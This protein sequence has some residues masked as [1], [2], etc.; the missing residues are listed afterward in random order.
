M[1]AA[2]LTPDEIKARSDW[3]IFSRA[4]FDGGIC[5]RIR[6]L[7]IGNLLSPRILNILNQ[8][9]REQRPS[10]Y[11]GSPYMEQ[12]PSTV[13][14]KKHGNKAKNNV[15]KSNLSPLNLG[16]TLDDENEGGDGII[17]LSVQ[18]TSNYLV[19]ENVDVSKVRQENYVDY[20]DF[21]NN[22]EPVYLDCYMKGYLV[23][24]TFWQQL[25]PHLCMPDFDSNTPVG[26]LSGEMELLIRNRPNN[27]P[28][29][30]AY[31]NTISVRSK[32]QCFLIETEQHAIG[33]LD[34]STC[35]YPAWNDVR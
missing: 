7:P 3:W 32:N 28:W 35:P 33:I 12:P 23:P 27:A 4:Y 30:V 14:P 29:T 15:N 18:F 9:R 24:V 8:G 17:F 22:P 25:V 19:Y 6:P 1:P 31:T 5:R 16:N 11:K 34:G 26:W 21:L 20:M 10:F 2:R 13:L